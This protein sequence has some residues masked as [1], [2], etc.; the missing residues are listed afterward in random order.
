MEFWH[1]D[2]DAADGFGIR[3]DEKIVAL[4]TVIDREPPVSE[5]GM[6]VSQDSQGKGL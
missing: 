2:P 4:A 5:C 6:E 1:C 3:E